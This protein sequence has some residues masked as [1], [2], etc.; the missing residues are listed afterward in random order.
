M[1]KTILKLNDTEK[2]V[3]NFEEPIENINYCQEVPI[4][5]MQEDTKF[6]FSDYG[7]ENILEGL[8][9]KISEALND[10]LY[11]HKSIDGN[12]GYL[13]AHQRFYG[14]N[15][16][17]LKQLGY[18]FFNQ[19]W[20][21]NV[22]VCNGWVGNKHFMC[23]YDVAMWIYNDKDGSIVIEYTPWYDNDDKSKNTYAHYQNFLK[24]YKSLFVRK[25]SHNTA[26]QWLTQIRTLLKLI[27]K[28]NKSFYIPYL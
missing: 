13:F 24:N 7:I 27:K 28:N 16:K 5:F 25:I 14:P 8:E 10:D 20:S 18:V 3:I 15:H 9:L 26:Q 21:G 19:E 23:A 22:W 17:I 12:I 4:F 11:L 6:L 1:Y 2:I